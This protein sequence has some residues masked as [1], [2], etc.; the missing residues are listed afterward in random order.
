MEGRAFFFFSSRR[1]HARFD[2]DWSSDVCSSDLPAGAVLNLIAR[3]RT[4]LNTYPTRFYG[5]LLFSRCFTVR[6]DRIVLPSLSDRHAFNGLAMLINYSYIP[7]R[8]GERVDG[9]QPVGKHGEG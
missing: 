9:K 8:R 1:R 2:C 6:F 5:S 3:P 7:L 4:R